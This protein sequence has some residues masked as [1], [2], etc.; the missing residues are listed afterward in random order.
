[1]YVLLLLLLSS[2]DCQLVEGET[3]TLVG[4]EAEVPVVTLTN[5]KISMYRAFHISRNGRRYFISKIED[6]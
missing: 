6:K 4:G 3:M 1:M 2:L 5:C